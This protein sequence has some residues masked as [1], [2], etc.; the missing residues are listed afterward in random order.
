MSNVNYLVVGGPGAAGGSGAAGGGGGGQV[1]SGADTVTIGPYTIVV[2]GVG[3]AS[4]FNSHSATFGANGFDDDSPVDGQ[5]HGGN[6]GNGHLGV[7]GFGGFP[8]RGGGGGGDGGD[9]SGAT[10]GVGTSSSITGTPTLYGGGGKGDD[11][12][13]G[14]SAATNGD[15]GTVIISYV[16]GALSATGGTISSDGAGNTVHTFSSNGTFT[17]TAI[18]SMFLMF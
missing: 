9:A 8:Q 16:T 11:T 13:G 1:L 10:G 15:P 12:I 4:S 17:V 5:G 6:S 3:A 7:N 18:G 2:G 14:G